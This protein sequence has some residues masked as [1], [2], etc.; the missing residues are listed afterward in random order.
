MRSSAPRRPTVAPYLA[1]SVLAAAHGL[2]IAGLPLTFLGLLSKAGTA[3]ALLRE[4]AEDAQTRL[5]W[6]VL[7]DVLALLSWGAGFLQ[8]TAWLA[9]IPGT[10]GLVAGSLGWREAVALARDRQGAEDDTHRRGMRLRTAT[11]ERPLHNGTA[12][13]RTRETEALRHAAPRG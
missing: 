7:F 11:G 3:V 5:G 6:S 13:D 2:S 9:I 1:V 4:S 12:A 10:V 8:P